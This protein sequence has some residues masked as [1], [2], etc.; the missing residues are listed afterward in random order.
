MIAGCIFFIVGIILFILS[1][2]KG[3][4]SIETIFPLL[5]GMIVTVVGYFVNKRADAMKIEYERLKELENKKYYKRIWKISAF[6]IYKLENM[7][8][9]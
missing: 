1:L 8:I 6:Y 9:Y 3:S 7:M 2:V 4:V 5:I